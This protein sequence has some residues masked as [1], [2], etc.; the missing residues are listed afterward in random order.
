MAALECRDKVVALAVRMRV[1][2]AWAVAPVLELAPV[3][4]SV[5]VPV[6]IPVQLARAGWAE[7]LPPR[8]FRGW[9]ALVAGVMSVLATGAWWR[10]PMCRWAMCPKVARL[11][12]V[13]SRCQA[14]SR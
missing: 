10:A 9:W 6:P 12:S 7:A 1:A 3:L 5:P 2:W 11:R 13:A 4:V 14:A 8:I